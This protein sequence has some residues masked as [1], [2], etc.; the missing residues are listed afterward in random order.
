VD[1]CGLVDKAFQDSSILYE[2]LYLF[3]ACLGFLLGSLGS[4]LTLCLPGRLDL[5]FSEGAQGI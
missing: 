2:G 5:F 3:V 4:A 1:P